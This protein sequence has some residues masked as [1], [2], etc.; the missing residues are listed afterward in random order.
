MTSTTLERPSPLASARR[1]TPRRQPILPNAVIGSGVFV[2]TELMFFTALISAYMVLKAGVVGAWVPPEDLR[3]PV[4]TTAIN[5]LVLLASGALLVLSGIYLRRS[6]GLGAGAPS[7]EQQ[8]AKA[9]KAMAGSVLLGAV[10]VGV[11][12]YEW[13]RLMAG[14]MTLASG[15]FSAAFY[16]L[17]GTH[18]LHALAVVLFMAWAYLSLRRGRWHSPQ[19]TGLQIFW[20]FIVGIWPVLYGLVY[21]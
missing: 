18:G 14:G 4:V 10:F 20:L 13:L 6:E 15:L 16:L 8:H 12:G 2:L 1:I 11:Q 19:M 21:F 9:V 3:L 7:K 5:T 17:I